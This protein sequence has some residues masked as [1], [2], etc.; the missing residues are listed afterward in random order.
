V[1]GVI[2]RQDDVDAFS[3]DIFPAVCG[4]HHRPHSGGI[5]SPTVRGLIG[6]FRW[7]F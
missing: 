6:S 3:F 4:I 2:E 7:W 5:P 1:D